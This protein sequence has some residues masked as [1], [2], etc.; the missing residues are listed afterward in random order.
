MKKT[1]VYDLETLNIFTATF[2]DKDSDEKRVFAITD[3]ID[4]RKELFNFLNTEVLAL[5]GYNCIHFDAQILEYMYRRPNCTVEEIRRYAQIITSDND[6]RP[7]VPEWNLRI[8]H[9]DLFR[10]LSL[11]TKAKRTGLKW[12]EFQLDME[13][14]EDMPSQG[15][16][17][18]WLEMVLSYNENDVIA[19]KHL[20][21][22]F[23]SEIELRK[24]IT[25]DTGVNVM[26]S[27][28]PD[29]VKKLFGKYL[30]DAM[31]ISTRDLRSMHTVRHSVDIGNIILPYVNFKTDV[32]KSVL[33]NFRKLTIYENGK[34]EDNVKFSENLLWQGI[35]IDFG[36]GGIHAARPN[37]VVKSNATHMIKTCDVISMY[38]NLMIRNKF[39]PAHLPKDI[40]LSLYEGFLTTRLSI[41]KSNP[42]NYFYKILLNST[43]G[44][45]NDDYS[46]LR[47]REVT[48]AIC[49]NGQLSILMLIEMLSIIPE[50]KLIMANTDGIEVY[51]PREYEELYYNICKKW[52][53]ITKLSLEYDDYNSMII[54]DVNNYISINT[55]SKTK[56]K[57]KYEFENI[58]L[59]KNKSYPIIAKA[60]Y[61]Y[62]VNNTP[63]EETI[64]NH[65][66]IFDFCAGVK[67]SWSEKKG[68]SKYELFR[69]VKGK[70]EVKKL[71]KTVRYYISKEGSTLIKKYED[72]SFEQ[73]EAPVANGKKVYKEWKVTYFN[74]SYQ[75]DMEDYNIDYSYYIYNAR[76]W[77]DAIEQIGQLK[78]L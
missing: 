40:F 55:K 67:S 20:F 21:N 30:S 38:P 23:Y 17:D 36:L 13:N 78:L 49:I 25:K 10:A 50:M 41:P 74:K 34:L 26:N 15:D 29:M 11:S 5:I 62:W 73:V 42:W 51:I 33:D 28:E 63:I 2:I 57:G 8:V 37:T 19:T 4:E 71:S 35:E 16:G 77:I 76:K 54:S 56:C 22:A 31:K 18:N 7:D 70:I 53:E 61:E 45:T 48:L 59:H 69:V 43:Y 72:G 68:R 60:V 3:T 65:K 6:K 58:P 75:L 27:T 32:F 44:L 24:L 66:N 1:Y 12:C 52:E 46:F 9:L 64:K 39:C 47:D 14:I